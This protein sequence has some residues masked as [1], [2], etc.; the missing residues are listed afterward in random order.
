M[1]DGGYGVIRHIQDELY[2]GRRFFHDLKSPSLEDLARVAGLHYGKVSATA[3][4][5]DRVA[6]ALRVGGPSLVE[7]DMA[8]IGPYPPYFKPPPYAQKK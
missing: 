4:L 5:G 2:G 1:N 8:A 6:E 3:E 7:V